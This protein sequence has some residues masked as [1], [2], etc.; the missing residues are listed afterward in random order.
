LTK[1]KQAVFVIPWIPYPLHSGGA[2]RAFHLA[3]LLLRKFD[4]EIIIPAAEPSLGEAILNAFGQQNHEVKVTCV[5][6]Q[7]QRRGL[8]RRA[9]DKLVTVRD[10]GSLLEPVNSLSMA[11][12]STLKD[13]LL[14]RTADLIV[15]TE[16]ESM[17]CGRLAKKLLPDV[18]IVVDMH[19]VNHRLLQRM[20]GV[21]TRQSI[22]SKDSHRVFK[23]ESQLHQWA[24]YCFA[25]SSEDLNLLQSANQNRL[26]GFVVPN[27]VDTKNCPYQ[28][29]H[30]SALSKNLVFCGSLTTE[31]NIG[32]L[33]WF[34]DHVWPQIK[35]AEPES[36]LL[37][38]GNDPGDPR[39]RPLRND[40]TLRF[41]GRVA[42]LAASYANAGVSICPVLIGSGTRLKI[43]EAMSYGNPVVSTS[44]GCEGL[45]ALDNEHILV[46]DS[47]DRF[48]SGIL[49]LMQKPDEF[50]RI[51]MNAR[52]FVEAHYDWDVIGTAMHEH[53]ADIR[54]R[55]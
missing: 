24:D 47:P 36:S 15:L 20:T 54:T 8:I 30:Q 18:P 32:G 50:S 35:H 21:D 16:L 10:T 3:R 6:Y 31:A 5:A 46:R 7:T 13:R 28:Q 27:G 44:I 39:L 12:R 40:S 52:S 34:Y 42:E 26:P 41:T 19:N 51:S 43:L 1:A 9:V 29:G 11:F 53:L 4:L 38:V 2:L 22:D 55:S 37:V 48:A 45:N 33:I 14:S 17:L 23:K 49:E 25:C